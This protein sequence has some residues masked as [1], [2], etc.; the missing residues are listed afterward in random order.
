MKFSQSL[1]FLVTTAL[2]IPSTLANFHISFVSSNKLWAI[3][4]IE[5]SCFGL[6]ADSVFIE[7]ASALPPDYIGIPAGLCGE[8]PLNMYGNSDGTWIFYR[9]GTTQVVGSCYPN[10]AY[11]E[12][13]AARSFITVQDQLVCYTTI[14]GN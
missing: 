10:V 14:C 2:T 12:C 11:M 6:Y 8:G 9:A 4:S 5:Y 7:S 13:P 1:V 3:P